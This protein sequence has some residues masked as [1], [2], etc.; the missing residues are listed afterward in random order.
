MVSWGANFG[1][2]I[3]KTVLDHDDTTQSI[4]KFYNFNSFQII[5]EAPCFA[6]LKFSFRLEEVEE[7]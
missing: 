2:G 1:A 6:Y 5:C 4:T 3:N 7:S